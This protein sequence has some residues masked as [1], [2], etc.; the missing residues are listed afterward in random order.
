MAFREPVF[1]NFRG[2]FVAVEDQAVHR[3]EGPGYADSLRADLRAVVAGRAGDYR[4]FAEFGA[5]GFDYGL[6]LRVEGPEVPHVREVVFHLFDI[7]HAGED[8]YHSVEACGEAHGPRCDGSLRRVLFKDFA[9]FLGRRGQHP[10]LD[11]L[12]DDYRLVVCARYFI[13]SARLH[14]GVFPV[15]V[16]YLELDEFHLGVRGEDCFQLLGRRVERE[17]NVLD[18]SLSLLFLYEAPH[19]EVVEEF[20]A[21][22]AEVVEQVEVEISCASAFE[23][24]VEL[25]YRLFACFAVYPRGVLRR[26]LVAFARIAFDERCAYRLFAARVGPR[27]VEVC[28]ARR[29]EFIDHRLYLFDVYLFALLGQ[30]HESEAQFFYFFSEV[31]HLRPSP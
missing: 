15:G 26:E 1:L 5:R 9:H 23:R 18:E 7:A 21:V 20:R 3:G 16:V 30:A 8:R 29:H 27:G 2:L 25:A 6:F 19:V 12:H 28:E 10:A 11:R 24:Q 14:G 31:C 22:L 17:S 13:A 4:I